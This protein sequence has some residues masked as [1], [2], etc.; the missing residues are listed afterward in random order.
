MGR[1]THKD[2]IE[3]LEREIKALYEGLALE[4]DDPYGEPYEFWEVIE[5]KEVQL[6]EMKYEIG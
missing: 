4:E 2:D 1:Y 6:K 5:R 3:R